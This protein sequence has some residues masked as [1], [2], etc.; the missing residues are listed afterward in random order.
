[1]PVID[2]EIQRLR[3]ENEELRET[4]RQLRRSLAP[5]HWVRIRDLSLAPSEQALVFALLTSKEQVSR[6]RCSHMIATVL[7]NLEDGSSQGVNVVLSRLR[8]KLNTLKPPVEIQT[9]YGY[10][11]WLPPVSRARL[12]ERWENPPTDIV[13][14]ATP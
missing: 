12:V 13:L 9:V 5:R 7:G 4:I 10:G 2:P 3:T 14:P 1:M 11:L 6:E 8:K